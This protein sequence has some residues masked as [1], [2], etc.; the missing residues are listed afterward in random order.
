MYTMDNVDLFAKV[1]PTLHLE[2][3]R[4][5]ARKKDVLQNLKNLEIFYLT[6]NVRGDYRDFSV[7]GLPL[8]N[9]R[10]DLFTMKGL[11]N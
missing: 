2:P 7:G 3:L 10:Y 9:H 1:C 4:L 5:I 11:H 8:Y 6:G